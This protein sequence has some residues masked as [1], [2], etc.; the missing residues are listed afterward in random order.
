MRNKNKISSNTPSYLQLC[1]SRLQLMS[2]A[3]STDGNILP[4]DIMHQEDQKTE[5]KKNQSSLIEQC[6]LERKHVGSL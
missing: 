3:G 1:Y 4:K 6:N 5:E 2:F